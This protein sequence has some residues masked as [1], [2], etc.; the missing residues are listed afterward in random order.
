MG[1]DRLA[2]AGSRAWVV[3]IRTIVGA[4]AATLA[5]RAVSLG[6]E[7]AK[8]IWNVRAIRKDFN[9]IQVRIKRWTDEYE[10]A[11]DESREKSIVIYREPDGERALRAYHT[12]DLRLQQAAA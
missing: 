7:L 8:R 1:A 9:S 3:W 10:S 5:V 4:V 2:A 11:T 6:S 12:R